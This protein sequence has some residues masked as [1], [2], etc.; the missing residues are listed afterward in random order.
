MLPGTEQGLARAMVLGD[1]TGVDPDTAEAFRVA[2][3][4]H[5][6]AI[7]GAQVALVAGILAALLARLRSGPTLR[8]LAIPV[9]LAF[10]AQ[11]VGGDAPVVRAA[12]MA[13]VLVAGRALDLDADL[14]NLLGLAALALLVHR[15]SSIGDIGFQLSFGAT[16]GLAVAFDIN[17][18]PALPLLC[19]GFLAPN[20]DLLWKKMRAKGAWG[21]LARE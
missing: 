12:V 15:P 16:L 14:A 9:S 5:I 10:Y 11:L 19:L 18:L 2:G 3:T 20:A 17:G 8:A 6:L 1:R 13:S 21:H 7:S 4:Y